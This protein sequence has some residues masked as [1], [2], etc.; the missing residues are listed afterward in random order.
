MK[1]ISPLANFCLHLHNVMFFTCDCGLCLGEFLMNSPVFL[2]YFVYFILTPPPPPPPT[3]YE[4][5]FSC[6]YIFQGGPWHIYS[7]TMNQNFS[8][9]NI[10]FYSTQLYSTQHNTAST[11][12]Q[13][14]LHYETF[15]TLCAERQLLITN[16]L[17]N[18]FLIYIRKLGFYLTLNLSS[19]RDRIDFL[20]F[21]I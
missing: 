21:V 18:Q 9:P 3:L 12:P 6:S 19:S 1:K 5:F 4:V 20:P 7:A 2:G 16:R 15:Q 14:I 13:F 10:L 8:I 17:V 11:Y